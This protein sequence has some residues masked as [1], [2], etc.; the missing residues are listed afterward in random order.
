M[1]LSDHLKILLLEDHGV[2]RAGF[3][4]LLREFVPDAQVYEA[5]S[6][7]QAIAILASDAIDFAFLDFKLAEAADKSGLD[8]LHYIREQE[9]ATRAVMLSGGEFAS[10]YLAKE[11]VLQ[12]INA[13]AFG[14][15]PKA[16]EGDGVLR[17][18]FET[19]LQGRVFLP[20]FVFDYH[21]G[22]GA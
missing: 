13:G 11:L 22:A 15:I 17:E 19:V 2:V 7:D 14:Y 9:L 8:V 16:M 3:K 1:A 12:C 21:A 18:A 10:G 5:A 6:Y 4:A 20:T